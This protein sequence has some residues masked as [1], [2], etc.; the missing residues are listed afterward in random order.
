[1]QAGNRG[2]GDV[3]VAG[4]AGPPPVAPR[5][6]ET[7]AALRVMA[8]RAADLL[9]SAPAATVPIP[10]S[11]WTV[12]DA[13]AHLVLGARLYA[14]LAAGADSPFTDLRDLAG[15]NARLLG[16]FPERR[17]APLADALL[18]AERD[19]L[20]ALTGRSG[21]EPV[22][23]HQGIPLTLSALAHL[24]LGEL[25]I[26]GWDIARGVGRPWPIE[27]AHARLVLSSLPT[28]LPWFV[29]ERAA[30]GVRARYDIRI[31]RGPRFVCH[32]ADGRL[33]IEPSGAGPVDCIISADPVAFL[34]VGYGRVSQWGP[35]LRGQMLAWGRKPWLAF[36]FKRL[37]RNP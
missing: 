16:Q 15:T 6:D 27:P 5:W 35:I 4:A 26:H 21:T 30:R 25:L 7:R 20:A 18:A 37:L 33:T 3:R 17:A 11:G 32:V 28:V 1:M 22:R 23:W 19:F 31:R 8:E 34:L 24:Q 2:D 29:D 36:A 10:R 14:D 12:A 13:A 9:R